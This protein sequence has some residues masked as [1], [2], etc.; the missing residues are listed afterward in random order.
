MSFRAVGRSDVG[1]VRPNNE[2]SLLASPDLVAVSDGVGGRPAGEVASQLA[3]SAL[4][5][6]VAAGLDL[7]AGFHLASE[8]VADAARSN[9]LFTGM[10][11]TLTAAVA[12][13]GQV[14]VA[15]VGDSRAW[16]VRNG[17]ARRLTEDQTVAARLLKAGEITEE[18]AAVHPKRHTLFQCVGLTKGDEPLVVD[19]HRIAPQPGDRLVLATDGLNYAGPPDLVEKLMS[20]PGDAETIADSLVAAALTA[21]GHDNVTIVVADVATTDSKQV[22]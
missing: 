20:A 5:N 9:S 11:A 13:R 8:V 19:L 1:S 14:L 18:E 16:L 15:H 3:V 12:A 17:T 2:D 10:C 4:A 7:D 22:G 6:A 21:G